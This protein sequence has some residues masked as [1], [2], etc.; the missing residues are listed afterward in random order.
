MKYWSF[1]KYIPNSEG[2]SMRE[3]VDDSDEYEFNIRSN[4]KLNIDFPD[5]REF[6]IGFFVTFN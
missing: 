3:T 5:P 4:N 6:L 1:P 2:I